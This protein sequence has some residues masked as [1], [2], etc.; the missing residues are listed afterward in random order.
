MSLNN[1]PNVIVNNSISMETDPLGQTVSQIKT[2]VEAFI[3]YAKTTFPNAKLIIFPLH[4]F[5]WLTNTELSR[6]QTILDTINNSGIM[7]TGDFIFWTVDD[8]TYSDDNVHLTTDGYKLLANKILSF[9]NGSNNI[10]IESLGFS[11]GEN[12]TNINFSASKV[13]NIVYVHGQIRYNGGT[14][15]NASDTTILSFDKGAFITGS[16]NFNFFIPVLLYASGHEAFTNVNII[17][18]EMQI[19]R[20]INFSTFSNPFIYINGSFPI[21]ISGIS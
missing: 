6:Y 4:T 18:G 12:F 1:S 7:T 3:L 8:R 21:G 2:N 17:N 14:L 19:G 5:K 16:S 13:G 15:P 11:L 10:E 20:P 9:V